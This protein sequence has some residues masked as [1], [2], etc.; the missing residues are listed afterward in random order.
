MGS[1]V[2][3]GWVNASGVEV[4]IP[5][6]VF[7]FNPTMVGVE[8]KVGEGTVGVEVGAS[9]GVFVAG[10][11]GSVGCLPKISS[12]VMEQAESKKTTN[13]SRAIFFMVV[14]VLGAG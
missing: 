4:E 5:V 10:G 6:G 7:M 9:V 12:A 14:I 8:V 3:P 2:T 11:T 13:S 1:K